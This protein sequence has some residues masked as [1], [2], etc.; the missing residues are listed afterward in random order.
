M[1]YYRSVFCL[2]WCLIVLLAVL[3]Q[4]NSSLAGQIRELRV[5]MFPLLTQSQAL[6]AMDMAAEGKSWFHQRMPGVSIRWIPL[7]TGNDI[8]EAMLKNNLDIAYIGPGP[9]LKNLSRGNFT[10]RVLSGSMRGGAALVVHE[11]NAST[12][13]AD[14]KGK[15]VTTPQFGSAQDAACRAWFMDAGLDVRISGGDVTILPTANPDIINLFTSG[16]IDG[17]WTLEPWVSRLEQ[18]PGAK[19]LHEEHDAMTTVLIT[20]IKVLEKDRRTLEA[21]T[22]AHEELTRWIQRNPEEAQR[23]VASQLSRMERRPFPLKLVENAWNRLTFDT[24][25]CLNG[26]EYALQNAKRAGFVDKNVNL[27]TLLEKTT[28][29]GCT[30]F[31]KVGNP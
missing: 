28:D 31:K 3:L 12:S 10:L 19:V 16:R 22:Y 6:I 23:R 5:G 1:K 4:C 15:R 29:P 27:D 30:V 21:F 8:V 17:A 26:F 2:A 7:N 14:F 20:G 24:H 9:V 18:I 11:S 25:V 13:A